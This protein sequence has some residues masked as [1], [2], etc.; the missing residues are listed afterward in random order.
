MGTT[1]AINVGIDLGTSR[2]V[3]ACD[4]GIRTFVPSFVGYAKDAVTE[5]MLGKKIVFGNEALKYKMG[6]ELYKPIENGVIR[7]SDESDEETDGYKKSL[8]V[9]RE[10]LKHVVEL[11]VKDEKADNLIIRGVVGAPA[12]ATLNN[13]KAI[14]NITKGILNDVMVVSEPFTVAYHLGCLYNYLIIDIGAGTV[15]LC[16]MH[17]TIPSPEDQITSTLAGDHIDR[18][19]LKLVHEKYEEANLTVNMIKRFK[20]ENAFVS[21]QGERVTI[22]IPVHGKPRTYDVTD[23]LRQ[24]CKE[25]VPDIV[26]GIRKLVATFDPEYQN[27]L[28]GNIILAGGGSQIVGLKKEIETYMLET[29]GYGRVTKIEEPLF[30]GANGALMLARDMPEEYWDEIADPE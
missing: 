30:A 18:T 29:L 9:S 28:K 8:E 2:T 14:L 23:E 20:E 22:D 21:T 11:A 5:K 17:G 13:K 6:L 4:N 24:A 10:L 12:L 19:F 1:K 25:I 16:R 7:Y 26:E 27:E 15:D 3:I